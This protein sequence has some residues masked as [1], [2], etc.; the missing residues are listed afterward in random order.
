MVENKLFPYLVLLYL[1]Y[2]FYEFTKFK[3]PFL[4]PKE[5]ALSF[6]FWPNTKIDNFLG[7]I[8]KFIIN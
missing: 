3:L 8:R 1:F 4:S 2:L 5:K 7:E 6:E